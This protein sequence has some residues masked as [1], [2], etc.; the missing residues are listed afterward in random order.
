MVTVALPVAPPATRE[1][2]GDWESVAL[3][4]PE[5]EGAPLVVATCV[6]VGTAV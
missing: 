1:P 3:G 6:G 2:L 4:E 5:E